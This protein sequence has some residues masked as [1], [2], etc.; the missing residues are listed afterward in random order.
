[1]P[2]GDTIHY[3]ASRIR[4]L[5]QD[6]DIIQAVS[7]NGDV[8]AAGLAGRRVIEVQ[9]RGKHLL[10]HT[11]DGPSVHS[12]LGM[13][14]SWRVA[15]PGEQFAKPEAKAALILASAMGRVACFFPK[16]LKV[17]TAL[18]L[19]GDRFLNDLGPDLLGDGWADP[20]VSQ[21][22]TIRR[23]RRRP[24]EA[25][26]VAMM[27]Q[28]N[29]CGMGNVYKSEIL[30]LCRLYPFDP[31]G[32]LDDKRLA[33][34]LLTA[35]KSMRRNLGGFARRTRHGYDGSR[36]WVYRRSGQP[37]LRCGATILMQRQGD[38]GRS[39]YWCPACQTAIA[40]A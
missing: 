1:M 22:E 19:R 5:L 28:R 16:L 17:V 24:Q 6:R 2:E 4:P 37:C 14:G 13:T 27:D 23:L 32:I 31:I 3:A 33:E 20:P 9:A 40:K 38:L 12:H 36:H 7:P 21:T 11:Q 34:L 15:R 18:H 26:G 8:E 25:L 10:I 30:F 39:T 35:R 29:V